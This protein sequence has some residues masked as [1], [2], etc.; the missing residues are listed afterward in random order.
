MQRQR[1][2]PLLT[3]KCYAAIGDVLHHCSNKYLA[4]SLEHR[5]TQGGQTGE[6]LLC[7]SVLSTILPIYVRVSLL[8]E[9]AHIELSRKTPTGLGLLHISRICSL[10]HLSL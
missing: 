7:S 1:W 10:L 4:Q 6:C 3:V 8:M 5:A 2:T 9:E